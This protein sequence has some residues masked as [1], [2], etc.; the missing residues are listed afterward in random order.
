MEPLRLRT[1]GAIMNAGPV[2]PN[3]LTTP[4]LAIVQHCMVQMEDEGSLPEVPINAMR[5]LELVLEVKHGF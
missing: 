5:L 4:V 3:R 1:C 2:N